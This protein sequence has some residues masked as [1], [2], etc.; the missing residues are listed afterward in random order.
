MKAYIPEPLPPRKI[1][2]EPLIS[3]IGK[4]NYNW[5]LQIKILCLA[6]ETQSILCLIFYIF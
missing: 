4:A 3:L 5:Q 1:D 2:W 6:N